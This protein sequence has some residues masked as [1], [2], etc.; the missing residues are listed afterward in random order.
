MGIPI[1]KGRPFR[2]TDTATST[3]VAI[4]DEKLARAQ[5]PNE[6]PIGKRVKLGAGPWMEVV[7]VAA[8][9][10]QAGL[11][12]DISLTSPSWPYLYLP[13]SQQIQRSMYFAIRTASKP[14][15]LISA[16]RARVLALDSEL[17]MF[18]VGTMEQAVARS[19][20]PKRLT[21]L[22]LA[23]FALTGLS[24]AV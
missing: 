19:L 11:D 7:G 14:E 23:G 12:E 6:N 24:L 22:L 3:P 16:V 21:R 20:S 15:A 1:L 5:W 18:E 10:K 4:V 2:P 13:A 17:P 8:D 9:V